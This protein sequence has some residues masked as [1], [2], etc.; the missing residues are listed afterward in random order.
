MNTAGTVVRNRW[1]PA[2][3]SDETLKTYLGPYRGYRVA[4]RP[5][6]THYVRIIQELWTTESGRR[7]AVGYFWRPIACAN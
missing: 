7:V 1:A 4:D 2:W 5:G 6:W 3:E